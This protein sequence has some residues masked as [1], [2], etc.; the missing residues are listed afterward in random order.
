MFQRSAV[1]F[2]SSASGAR[3]RTNN[4][5]GGTLNILGGTLSST[6]SRVN[7]GAANLISGTLSSTM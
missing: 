6:N 1:D 3:C 4:V 5:N 7:S 2:D